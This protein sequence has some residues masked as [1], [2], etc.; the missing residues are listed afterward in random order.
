MEEPHLIRAGSVS[1]D[2]YEARIASGCADGSAL[3][4]ATSIV[5]FDVSITQHLDAATSRKCEGGE[6]Q[7]AG[8]KHDG[9]FFVHDKLEEDHECMHQRV[10]VI[11]LPLAPACRD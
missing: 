11:A 10:L 4:E 8:N 6:F 3:L 9:K 2:L 7:N 1:M 5:D